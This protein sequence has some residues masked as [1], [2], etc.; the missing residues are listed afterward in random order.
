MAAHKVGMKVSF[1]NI[2]DF[3]SAL[4]SEST[5]DTLR[6]W[7]LGLDL[8]PG[9]FIS[10]TLTIADPLNETTRTRKNEPRILF[11]LKSTF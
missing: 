1:K 8:L 10:G 6:S 7:G 11:D 4:S 3:R 2:L 9:H 5:A